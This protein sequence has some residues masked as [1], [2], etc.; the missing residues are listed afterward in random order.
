MEKE[1]RSDELVRIINELR[2]RNWSDT[3][4]LEFLLVIETS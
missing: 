1:L 3:E 2:A 4:I